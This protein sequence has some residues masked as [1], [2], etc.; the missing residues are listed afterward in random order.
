MVIMKN[1]FTLLALISLL[2]IATTAV[3]DEQTP[4][5]GRAETIQ[6]DSPKKVDPLGFDKSVGLGPYSINPRLPGTLAPRF[7]LTGI[8][9]NRVRID[10]SK[11]KRPLVITFFR[12]GWCPYCLTQFSQLR[13][14]EQQ[15][16]DLGA[17][18]WFV[19]PDKPELLSF[20]DPGADANYQI[21]SD[22][23]LSAAKQFGIAYEVEPQVLKKYF[24]GGAL[25]KEYSGENESLLPVPASFVIN[26]DGI[27][28]FQYAN[29]D[30]TQ[31]INPALLLAA[32]KT[33]SS[34]IAA[35]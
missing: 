8:T 13:E 11:L 22:T 19:S 30:H 3:S 4:K 7:E 12:G 21:F 20:G 15:M 31:R 10:P 18:I 5:I 6:Q 26:P 34:Q 33:T 2:I 25:L 27:I 14:I 1:V 29:P 23:N 17:D 35:D 24:S 16:A 32:I 9:G 28:S